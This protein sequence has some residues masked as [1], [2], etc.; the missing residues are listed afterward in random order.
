VICFIKNIFQSYSVSIPK[1][2]SVLGEVLRT[3]VRAGP[4]SDELDPENAAGDAGIHGGASLRSVLRVQAR[5]AVPGVQATNQIEAWGWGTT[6]GTTG[7]CLIA[8]TVQRPFMAYA[9]WHSPVLAY[10]LEFMA[11]GAFTRPWQTLA[12]TCPGLRWNSRVMAKVALT[13]SWQ[14]LAFT[15]HG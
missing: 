12:F 7:I 14:T 3:T 1:S 11:E 9:A 6:N 2:W 5:S 4:T 13:R 10:T 8:R 15:C